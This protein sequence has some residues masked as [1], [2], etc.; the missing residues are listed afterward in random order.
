MFD[1]PLLATGLEH[2][3]VTLNPSPSLTIRQLR[4][5]LYDHL[6]TRQA[7]PV[8]YETLTS[9]AEAELARYNERCAGMTLG[10][11]RVD[12]LTGLW[13]PLLPN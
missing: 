10:I 13:N 11:G 6:V 7:P 12:K 8:D 9:E 5:I 4:E 3:Y 1:V 2:L